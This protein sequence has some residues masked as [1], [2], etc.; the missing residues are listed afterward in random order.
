MDGSVSVTATRHS[1]PSETGSRSVLP[2]DSGHTAV[3]LLVFALSPRQG[4]IMDA[5]LL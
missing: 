1:K 5:M 3:L 2:Q 4:A